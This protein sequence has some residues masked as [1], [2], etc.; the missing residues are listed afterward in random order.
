MNIEIANRLFELRKKNGLS[1][2]EL[3]EK[4]GVSRQA[5]SKWE[6]A[7]SSPDTDNLIQ[8]AQLYQMSL[9]ELLFTTEPVGRNDAMQ[10]GQIPA[11][12]DGI[13]IA[14]KDG[15]ELHIDRTGL[16]INVKEESN[17][18]KDAFPIVPI[19]VV[20]IYLVMGFVFSLWHPGWLVFFAIPIFYEFVAMSSAE[21]PRSKANLFP[22]APICVA[23]FL[24]LGF[25][26]DLWHPAWIVFLLIPIYH[27]FVSVTLKDR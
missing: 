19:V 18:H 11:S 27:F 14:D 25:L 9:D 2:E 23:V 17:E 8:L 15:T 20:A 3:A 6:R 10:A 12:G 5:V 26:C 16:R 13:H 7:E 21:G 22:M 4:I 1:Q 24:L